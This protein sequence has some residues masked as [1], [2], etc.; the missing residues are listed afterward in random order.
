MN[1]V[2]PAAV[3]YNVLWGAIVALVPFAL[4]RLLGMEL[5]NYPEIW[6]CVGM[7]LGGYA[8]AALD[9]CATGLLC[10]GA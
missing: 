5:P 6:Q 3:V 8:V 2:L 1:H 4:F 10:W 7:I 9:T